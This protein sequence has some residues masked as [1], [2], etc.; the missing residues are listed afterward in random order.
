[1]SDRAKAIEGA[2]GGMLA[3]LR[4]AKM[5]CQIGHVPQIESAMKRA[6]KA[7]DMEREKSND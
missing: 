7:L 6:E 2:L 4:T 3:T 1:M 5:S